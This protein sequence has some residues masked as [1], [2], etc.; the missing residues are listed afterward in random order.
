[1]TDVPALTPEDTGLR[2]RRVLDEVERAVY[3][4][5]EALELVWM[6]MLSGGHVLLEDLPG[7]GK[8]M[9]AR[10]F[11][12]VL[13]LTFSRVQFTPDLLPQDLTGAVVL[14]H[15]S[16]RFV[17]RE[18]PLFAQ[19][20]LADEVNRTP[21]KTQSALLEAMAERQVTVDGVTHPLPTPFVVLATQNPIEYE[22]TYALPE[23]QLDRFVLRTALGYLDTGGEA[24]MVRRRLD[25]R[26]AEPRLER[27][28]TAEELL[29]MMTALEYV[30]V[31]DD[32]LDYVVEIVA[33]T[34]DH[35]KT[36]V[37]ASPRGSLAV[38]QL[39]RA[40][41]VLEGR[42]HVTPDDVK[43]VVVPALGHRLV[44]KPEMWVARMTGDDLVREVL[45]RVPTPVVDPSTAIGADAPGRPRE[46]LT[47]DFGGRGGDR[48]W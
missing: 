35:P 11:A 22:G 4:K 46:R 39:A 20:L 44:L 5:R 28:C 9:L 45:A 42:A 41:A 2:S 43:R 12:Q 17:F 10:S 32:V 38:T 47:G 13:G 16:H 31:H 25:R 7:L 36:V 8:T 34:R 15:E 37:G 1:V 14:D 30:E 33:A 6:G 18:G 21:P 48:S 26:G 24:R 3:G 19:L 29:A 40:A 27:V 23:A